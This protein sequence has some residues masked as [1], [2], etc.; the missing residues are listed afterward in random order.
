MSGG[1]ACMVRLRS[2]G[3]RATMQSQQ[4]PMVP[5]GGSEK[6]AGIPSDI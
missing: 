6:K 4:S 3:P 5:R 1:Q 2:V